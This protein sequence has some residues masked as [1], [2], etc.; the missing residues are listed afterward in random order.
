M[1]C[2]RVNCMIYDS[3]CSI[4][5]Q[6]FNSFSLCWAGTLQ[7]TTTKQCWISRGE[8]LVHTIL[9]SVI[10]AFLRSGTWG[11]KDENSASISSKTTWP[12]WTLWIFPLIFGAPPLNSPSQSL[13]LHHLVSHS[14]LL[15]RKSADKE[16]SCSTLTWPPSQRTSI[17]VPVGSA[18][19]L[20]KCTSRTTTWS[21][22]C[23]ITSCPKMPHQFGWQNH[24]HIVK[25]QMESTVFHEFAKFHCWGGPACELLA[26]VLSFF[27][28]Q[29]F[30]KLAAP[31]SHHPKRPASC[32][33]C[34]LEARSWS[35]QTIRYLNPPGEMGGF[36]RVF[37]V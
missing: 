34:I 4:I 19:H 6:R 13:L 5:T 3:I 30:P 2:V 29:H 36:T 33:L 22:T 21:P 23:G 25:P 24:C 11:R 16:P 15:V 37:V 32:I 12:H 7:N 10:V 26:P 18:N 8:W 1:C 28:H 27:H 31:V 14:S 17:M 35:H 20:A 9:A